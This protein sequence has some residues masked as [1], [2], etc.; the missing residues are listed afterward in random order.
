V[1]LASVLD[2]KPIIGVDT[3]GDGKYVQL[4]QARTIN[5]AVKALAEI[6]KKRLSDTGPFRGQVVYALHPESAVEMQQVISDQLA[7]YWLPAS[8]LSLV[9]GAHTGPT[10]IG[11]IC[12]PRAVFE[13]VS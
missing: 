5:S 9:L 8:R 1:L 12:A 2:I 3:K 13:G 4:G 6:M 10:L 7:C 11:A